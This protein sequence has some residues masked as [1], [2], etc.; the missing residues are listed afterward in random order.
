MSIGIFIFAFTIIGLGVFFAHYEELKPYAS[1]FIGYAGIAFVFY[2]IM[3]LWELFACDTSADFERVF[4]DFLLFG[5]NIALSSVGAYFLL[6]QKLP[7]APIL[8]N[9]D[10]AKPQ[11]KAHLWSA[12][13]A[14]IL[15][16]VVTLVLL[17]ISSPSILKSNRVSFFDQITV[18]FQAI[19]VGFSEETYYRLFLQALFLHWFRK[20]A[21]GG[22]LSIFLTSIVWALSHAGILETGGMKF[23]QIFLMGIILGK[24]M[25]KRGFESC[26]IAHAGF[27][28]VAYAYL[29]DFKIASA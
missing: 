23:L 6:K 29:A 19:L 14:V 24:L 4:I 22:A 5:R 27:N 17:T 9:S 28:F 7:A 18:G 2:V 21:Y 16:L 26:V 10:E 20:A 12:F 11:W 1:I 13:S 25:M 15:M 8:L 3:Q